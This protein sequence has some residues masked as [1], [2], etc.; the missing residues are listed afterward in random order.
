M[1]DINQDKMAAKTPHFHLTMRV[2]IGI[3]VRPPPTRPEDLEEGVMEAVVQS[4]AVSDLKFRLQQ[5]RTN[6]NLRADPADEGEYSE[7]VAAATAEAQARM[8]IENMKIGSGELREQDLWECG[9]GDQS[10]LTHLEY[11][12]LYN[13][14]WGT[15]SVIQVGLR[16][17]LDLDDLYRVSIHL[18]ADLRYVNLDLGFSTVLLGQ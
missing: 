16:Q 17:Y 3:P 6:C 4:E 14:G 18:L 5:C 13:S 8:R 10:P 9:D 11:E 15:F 2:N 12:K 1:K 7:E